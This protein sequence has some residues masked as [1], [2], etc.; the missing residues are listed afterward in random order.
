MST[1]LELDDEQVDVMREILEAQQAQLLTENA[2]VG[3]ENFRRVIL[4]RLEVVEKL[5]QRLPK[6]ALA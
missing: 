6:Y 4:R 2:R 1:T 3:T 5:L